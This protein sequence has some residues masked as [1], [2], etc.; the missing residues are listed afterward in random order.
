MLIATIV[1]T[2]M[3]L[4]RTQMPTADDPP[5]GPELPIYYKQAEGFDPDP[6]AGGGYKNCSAPWPSA[7]RTWCVSYDG[8]PAAVVGGG[9]PKHCETGKDSEE[10][11]QKAKDW[12]SKNCDR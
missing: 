9:R 12:K 10:A 6:D 8:L 5:V 4:S 3:L 11:E 2:F 1:S 7:G